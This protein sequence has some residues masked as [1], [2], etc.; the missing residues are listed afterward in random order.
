MEA[1]AHGIAQ[2][3]YDLP[4]L[5]VESAR[6]HVRGLLRYVAPALANW[7]QDTDLSTPM[8]AALYLRL[9]RLLRRD[10]DTGRVL[11]WPIWLKGFASWLRTDI[12]VSQ[13]A[14]GTAAVRHIHEQATLLDQM[15]PKAPP[16]TPVN[17]SKAL[18]RSLAVQA[19]T[20]ASFV[21]RDIYDDFG[22]KV[23]SGVVR[24]ETV[25]QTARRLG[26]SVKETSGPAT[27]AAEG[28]GD[29]F[30]THAENRVERLVI[31]DTM[32]AYNVVATDTMWR[33]SEQNLELTWSKRWDASV[34][35]RACG[36]CRRLNGVVVGIHESFPGIITAPP[37]H[38]YCRCILTTYTEL[39]PAPEEND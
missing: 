2:E 23:L 15:R 31:T 37:L 13:Q 27:G 33:L 22:R 18:D 5:S 35:S 19:R 11:R 32:R 34:D 12:R 7:L 9:S 36:D 6:G 4:S 10:P 3:V 24:E 29:T 21:A 25:G 14:A 1:Y 8:T 20:D 39:R 26:A 17:A 30:I 28:I 16:I 38:S